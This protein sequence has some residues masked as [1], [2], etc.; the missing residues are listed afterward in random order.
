MNRGLAIAP[1]A[2]LAAL[3][4][5]FWLFALRHDP[6]VQPQALVGKPLPELTLPAL[7]DGRS[8]NLR[9]TLKGPALI[10]LFASWCAPCELEAPVLMT[11]QAQGVS[12][13]GIAYKDAPENT[14]AFLARVGDPYVQRLVDRQG[15]AGIELGVTGVPETYLVDAHGLILAKYAQPL[16]EADAKAIIAKLRH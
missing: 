11:L 15:R 16:S 2:A 3:A 6:H 1:L 14:K 10:N 5:L 4:L 9:Q 8:V 13:I 12:L 7:D